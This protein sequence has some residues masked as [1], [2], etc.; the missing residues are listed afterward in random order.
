MEFII[1]KTLKFYLNPSVIPFWVTFYMKK[2]DLFISKNLILHENI[3]KNLSIPLFNKENEASYIL[4][5]QVFQILDCCILDTNTLIFNQ[6]GLVLTCFYLILGCYYNLWNQEKINQE[7]CSNS[8][9]LENK[10]FK[11]FNFLFNKF[12][13]IFVGVE[14]KELLAYIHYLSNFF[15]IIYNYDVPPGEFEVNLF[16]F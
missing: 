8:K 14:L 5:R 15:K 2:W 16:F 9:V 11:S 10:E 7:F 13:T 3:S 1:C 12:S 6:R 4:F